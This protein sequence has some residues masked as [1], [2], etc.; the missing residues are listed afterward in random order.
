MWLGWWGGKRLVE[1]PEYI[2][3]E[4]QRF[5]TYQ[6]I[7][8]HLIIQRENWKDKYKLVK[9]SHHMVKSIVDEHLS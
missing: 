4:G 6:E 5:H 9:A 8:K 7:I 3:F 1:Y 2:E